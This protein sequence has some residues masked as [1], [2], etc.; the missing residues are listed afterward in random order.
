MSQNKKVTILAVDDNEGCLELV[1]NALHSDEIE[2]LTADD[3]GKAWEMIQSVRPPIVITDLV[4]P[5]MGGMDLLE[6]IEEF[7]PSIAV[8]LMTAHYSTES[9]IEAIR[10]GASDYLDKPIKVAMLRERIGYL[11]EDVRQRERARELEREMLESCRFEGIVGRSPLMWDV[12]SRI[13]RIGPHF[14]TVLITGE[15]GTGKDL[16][17][18]A[19]HRVSR[20]SSGRFVPVN[21]SAVVETL[22]ESEMF[23]Y[24]K[25]SFTGANQDKAGLFEHANGGVLFLDEVGDMSPGLQA[26]LL[27]ALQNQEVLRVGSLTPRKVDVRIVAATHYNLRERVI[28]GDFRED[29]FYRLAMVE[30]RVPPLRD[31]KED[32]PLLVEHLLRK[33]SREFGKEVRGLTQRAS[34]VLARHDWPGNVRELENVIGHACMMASAD[35]ADVQDLPGYLVAPSTAEAAGNSSGEPLSLEEH[36]RTLV[37]DA[38]T[39][40]GGNQ[41]EAARLL[42]I[43]R[44]ALRYKL[45][46]FGLQT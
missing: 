41:S 28:S 6:K 22:L 21:C 16:V 38:L 40:S 7:D 1:S 32:I 42:H 25:G 12:F 18:R 9:A 43:G 4:M 10:K 44:D 13:R 33:F 3:S 45:K 5:N 15:T 19:I 17:A 30:I 37:R 8:V 23:G 35:I 31:R 2:V 26:K 27:R 29:L 20:A 34:L 14:R 24:M 36:E 39:R 11:V 46:K